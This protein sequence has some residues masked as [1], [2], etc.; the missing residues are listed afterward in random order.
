[1]R[2]VNKNVMVVKTEKGSRFEAVYFVLKNGYFGNRGDVLREANRIVG[3]I[4]ISPQRQKGREFFIRLF[5][6][7][8]GVIFGAV[9][10]CGICT[11]LLV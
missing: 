10:G 2:G 11:L 8:G 7:V 9:V 4:G 6:L 3:N 5:F 1:M